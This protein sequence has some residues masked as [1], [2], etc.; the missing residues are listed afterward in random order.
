MMQEIKARHLASFYERDGPLRFNQIIAKLKDVTE[1]RPVN[2]VP[3]RLQILDN[4][5]LTVHV[6][7]QPKPS[8]VF[9][10]ELVEDVNGYTSRKRHARFPNL[11]T[12]RYMLSKVNGSHNY[13]EIHTFLMNTE[14]E[15]TEAVT[16]LKK[17]MY[18]AKTADCDFPPK[19]PVFEGRRYTA[20]FK[21][22]PSLEMMRRRTSAEMA[23]LQATPVLNA[24]R[25]ASP[26]LAPRQFSL[27][28]VFR[29]DLRGIQTSLNILVDEIQQFERQLRAAIASKDSRHRANAQ[30]PSTSAVVNHVKNIRKG[31]NLMAELHN[32]L[33]DPKIVSLGNCFLES[34]ASLERIAAGKQFPH[35]HD[36]LIKSVWLPTFTDQSVQFLKNY[37]DEKNKAFLKSLGPAWNEEG[38]QAETTSLDPRQL[39]A[40][41]YKGSDSS[42]DEDEPEVPKKPS[43]KRIDTISLSAIEAN[44][45]Q[46]SCTNPTTPRNTRRGPES[47]VSRVS[48]QGAA[49]TAVPPRIGANGA[50][51]KTFVN[52]N[53]LNAVR[54]RR[55][56]AAVVIRKFVGQSATELTVDVGDLVEVLDLDETWCCVRTVNA[57]TGH[58]PAESIRVLT[59]NI[60][61]EGSLVSYRSTKS[62]QTDQMI[63]QA[64]SRPG[65]VRSARPSS[66]SARPKSRADNHNG[67]R[68]ASSDG[69]DTIISTTAM[70]KPSQVGNTL[71]SQLQRAIRSLTSE[72]A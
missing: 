9:K 33:P 4:K 71:A 36:R 64:S 35:I 61:Q 52:Q 1:S 72:K 55:K 17:A 2:F 40:F 54:H 53:F 30:P 14:S 5:V 25:R 46:S 8:E 38:F 43:V 12:F 3:S 15:L 41:S 49:V 22:R 62:C 63:A 34:M 66:A 70:L 51:Q 47:L 23:K 39:S 19:L 31:I 67:K 42:S 16:M 32:H 27:D 37:L 28:A 26:E 13:D 65:T 18:S 6:N 20:Q 59:N 56:T 24:Q 44:D 7:D 69:S 68:A 50:F 29:D 58:V 60:E 57:T 45:T 10:L 48:G 11:L 21:R